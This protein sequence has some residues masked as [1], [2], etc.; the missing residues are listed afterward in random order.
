MLIL[1]HSGYVQLPILRDHI[2]NWPSTSDKNCIRGEQ[3]FNLIQ[4]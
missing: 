4:T 2:N 3:P 1:V